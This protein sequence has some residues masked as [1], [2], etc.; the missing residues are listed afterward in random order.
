MSKKNRR[1]KHV[2][3]SLKDQQDRVVG[4]TLRPTQ[5]QAYTVPPKRTAWAVPKAIQPQVFETCP[6]MQTLVF[7][8]LSAFK[9]I[10]ALHNNT[11]GEWLAYLGGYKSQ[12]GHIVVTNLR[13]PPQIATHGS[14]QVEEFVPSEDHLGVIHS[15][16]DIGCSFSGTDHEFINANHLLSLLVNT[17]HSNQQ[18][19]FRIEA[20]LRQLVTCGRQMR[21]KPRVQMYVPQENAEG[22]KAWLEASL[23]NIKVPPPATKRTGWQAAGGWS[24][25]GGGKRGSMTQQLISEAYEKM[26]RRAG[27][28]PDSVDQLA[29]SVGMQPMA[30]MNAYMY[31]NDL[32]DEVDLEGAGYINGNYQLWGGD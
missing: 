28:D 24:T 5:P 10:A 27:L 32:E 30:F 22:D 6:E 14:V 18:W 31:D 19:G 15:H 16:H 13:V 21:S 20:E 9:Q 25:T 26:F 4:G 11:K 23:A 2:A 8:A 3:D 12:T 29:A 17:D 1:R 7:V